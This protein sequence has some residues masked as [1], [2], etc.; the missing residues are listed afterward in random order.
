MIKAI[1]TRYKGYRFRSR[2][3]AR[4]AVFFDAMGWQWEYEPEGFELKNGE[5]YLPDFRINLHGAKHYI[6]V[7]GSG[8][9]EPSVVCQKVYMA[10]KISSSDDNSMHNRWR[11][12]IADKEFIGQKHEFYAE[13]E[14][15]R[16]FKRGFIY[17]GPHFADN[18]GC[19]VAHNRAHHQIKNADF[20]FVWIDSVDSFGTFHEIGF[21]HAKLKPIYIGFSRSM[22]VKDM[23]FL[24]ASAK[25]SGVFDSASEAWDSLIG[26]QQPASPEERKIVEFSVYNP[27]TMVVG[28]PMDANFWHYEN[29][30]A[31]KSNVLCGVRGSDIDFTVSAMRARSARFEHGETP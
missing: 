5:W 1:E 6:E 7:K 30:G 26:Y 14:G 2:L 12:S 13:G 3:E 9:F 16:F 25:K 4:W 27:I 21:A 8:S 22:P 15:K 29:A 28:D 31:S 10:G 17:E 23:W 18:H 19:V 11:Y 24:D 20:V